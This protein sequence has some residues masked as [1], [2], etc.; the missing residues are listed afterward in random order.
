MRRRSRLVRLE[1][2]R[3]AGAVAWAVAL[4]LVALALVLVGVLVGRVSAWL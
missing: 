1:E 3:D 2:R 4:G